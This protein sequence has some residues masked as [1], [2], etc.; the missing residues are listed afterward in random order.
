MGYPLF[1]IVTEMIRH[2]AIKL[3]AIGDPDQSIFDFAGT[4]P[5]YLIE[6]TKHPDMQPV[7]KLAK[8]YRA[9]SEIITVSK[10]ILPPYCDYQSDKQGGACQVFETRPYEQ[11]QLVATL[12]QKY[13]SLGVPKSR[14]AVLHPWRESKNGL[15]GLHILAN[16]LRVTGIEFTLDKNPHYDRSMNL[17]KWLED[18]GYW[19]LEGLKIQDETAGNKIFDEL[20]TTWS[21]IAQPQ[22]SGGEQDG[23]ARLQLAELIWSI[24]GEDMRLSEW[25]SHIAN[26]L[27][28]NLILEEYQ[29][30]FPDEVEE[31]AHLQQAVQQ[32][33]EL[34]EMR[35]NDFVNLTRGIQLTTLHSSKGMEFDVVIIA[36][37]ERI[38]NDENGKRLLYVG[39]T[40]AE[41]EVCLIYSRVWPERSPRTPQY[42]ERLV[43][44]CGP[45]GYF[46]HHPLQ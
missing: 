19:C 21:Q 24:K 33:G 43:Q 14:M 6:L 37:V 18:L 41:R 35:L 13:L 36:G 20:V 15:E 39:V 34:G 25:L 9:T 1:R 28:F 16:D 42:I 45:L 23:K 31:L 44:K 27:D 7:V 26:E 3:F 10:A 40:R 5:K 4:D 17:I 8:N 12:A 38:W 22:V 46:S 2:T 29:K 32:G 30:I 11:G